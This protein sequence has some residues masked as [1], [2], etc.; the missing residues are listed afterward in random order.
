M[1]EV[2]TG[3]LLDFA[4]S[5][6]FDIIVHGCNCFN[7]FGAGIAKQIRDRYPNAYDADLATISGDIKKLGNWTL[8]RVIN[9]PA[10]FKVINA[11]TQYAYYGKDDLFEY[12]A[13]NLILKK[14][15]HEYG[16]KNRFGFPLIGCGL[17][18]GDK[19]RIIESLENFSDA[20]TEKE[21]TVTLVVY[22]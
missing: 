10:D 18:G 20:V 15:E 4:D 12:D 2:I 22:E 9:Q 19:Q 6:Q 3:N 13:F 16:T 17:A 8:A 7:R 5:G 11:Y 14:L 1:I 21:S